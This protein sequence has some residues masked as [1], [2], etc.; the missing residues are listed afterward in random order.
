M[1]NLRKDPQLAAGG[2]GVTD[3]MKKRVVLSDTSVKA[4]E[5]APYRLD[6]GQTAQL[7]EY[8]IK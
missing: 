5:R 1:L 3:M 2:E 6:L 4:S 8:R 7:M